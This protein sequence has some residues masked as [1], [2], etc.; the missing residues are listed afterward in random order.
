MDLP[1]DVV[2]NPLRRSAM[3]PVCMDKLQEELTLLFVSFFAATSIWTLV[4]YKVIRKFKKRRVVQRERH[5]SSS[6]T[7][8]IAETRTPS[9]SD[10]GETDSFATKQQQIASQAWK[11]SIVELV[12]NRAMDKLQVDPSRSSLSA[13]VITSLDYEDIIDVICLASSPKSNQR[14]QCLPR[15][16]LNDLRSMTLVRR[17]LLRYLYEDLQSILQHGLKHGQILCRKP[18]GCGF[19]RRED[20]RIVLF[21]N[22]ICCDQMEREER[23]KSIIPG[24]R[25]L[26][27]TLSSPYHFTMTEKLCL[28]SILGLQGSILSHV[29]EPLYVDA[30]LVSS[31]SRA[32]RLSSTL[33]GYLDLMQGMKGHLN[34]PSEVISFHPTIFGVASPRSSF[35][36][37]YKRGSVGHLMSLNERSFCANWI[38]LLDST[39]MIYADTGATVNGKASRLCKASL[40][41]SF[42]NLSF[43]RILPKLSWS[44][45]QP[46]YPLSYAKVKALAYPYQTAKSQVLDRMKKDRRASRSYSHNF[47]AFEPK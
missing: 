29:I 7:D 22:S 40:F 13:I 1:D 44:S 35:P 42:A 34:Q 37:S 12:H 15:I 28:W 20:I 8:S 5:P 26:M 19:V 11:Q 47:H 43:A 17:C 39:E 36:L 6:E 24:A 31:R 3:M 32:Q 18:D 16:A 21:S 9:P 10:E 33:S 23:E 25:G 27:R 46:V 4:A 41:D 45:F 30:I 2:L 14:L 38:S